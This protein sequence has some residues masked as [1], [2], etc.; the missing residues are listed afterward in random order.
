MDLIRPN[1][2]ADYIISESRDRGDILTNL[3]LQKLLYYSQAWFLA[4]HDRSIFDEDFE[5]GLHGPSL[6]AQYR[7]FR[8]LEWRPITEPIRRPIMNANVNATMVRNHLN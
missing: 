5:P 6:P 4:L 7:R 1:L 8:H 2:I 3:K